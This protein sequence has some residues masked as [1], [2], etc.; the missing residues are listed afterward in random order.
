MTQFVTGHPKV[1]YAKDKPRGF[2][3]KKRRQSLRN[4]EGNS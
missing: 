1:M 3:V 4:N 2:K